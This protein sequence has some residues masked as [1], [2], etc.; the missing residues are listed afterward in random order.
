[1]ADSQ[2]FEANSSGGL[3]SEDD[4]YDAEVSSYEDGRLKARINTEVET[5]LSSASHSGS[6]LNT[7]ISNCLLITI[8]ECNGSVKH[9]HTMKQAMKCMC[10][11][12]LQISKALDDEI[13]NVFQQ[14]HPGMHMNG[15]TVVLLRGFLQETLLWAVEE[16]GKLAKLDGED[17]VSTK[18]V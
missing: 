1:M 5:A 4:D 11:S 6:Y 13:I 12:D 2:V 15:D 18:Q 17:T 8:V 3:H 7:S 10:A 14:Y 16:S 9:G